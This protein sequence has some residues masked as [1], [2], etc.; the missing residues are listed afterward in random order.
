MP[1]DVHKMS[2]KL[3][4]KKGIDNP[5][6]LAQ[7]MKNKGYDISAIINKKELRNEEIDEYLKDKPEIA[8]KVYKAI[9]D[10]YV[11]SGQEIPKGLTGGEDVNKKMWNERSGGTGSGIKGHTT[12]EKQELKEG[13]KVFIN[14]GKDFEGNKSKILGKIKL[15]FKDGYYQVELPDGRT[16]EFEGEKL[17]K[18]TTKI[19]SDKNIEISIECAKRIWVENPKVQGGGFYRND[20]RAGTGKQEQP[21]GRKPAVDERDKPSVPYGDAYIQRI[22]QMS[23]ETDKRIAEDLKS[24]KT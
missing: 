24:G 15:K 1:A 16:T 22:K 12:L 14:I 17:E 18:A 2:E 9:S 11:P 13:D 19:Y 8:E 10:I 20:P 23:D 3:E 5:Y 21:T 6:A 7:W 4:D